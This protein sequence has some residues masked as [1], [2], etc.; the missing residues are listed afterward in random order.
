MADF[1]EEHSVQMAGFPFT[2]DG[3]V[4]SYVAQPGWLR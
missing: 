3:R 1:D 2:D 4:R